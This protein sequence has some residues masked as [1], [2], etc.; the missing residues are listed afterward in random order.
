M[1]LPWA[2]HSSIKRGGEGY[3]MLPG[4]CRRRRRGK[5]MEETACAVR[6]DEWPGTLAW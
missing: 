1:R 6:R 4:T 3:V 2:I 5:T